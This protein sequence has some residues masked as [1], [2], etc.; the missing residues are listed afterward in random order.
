MDFPLFTNAKREGFAGK[1]ARQE[2]RSVRSKGEI[3]RMV[4]AFQAAEGL[5]LEDVQVVAPGPALGVTYPLNAFVSD[6]VRVE[7]DKHRMILR[8]SKDR[9]QTEMDIFRD[10]L[11]SFLV[12]EIQLAFPE[13]CCEGEWV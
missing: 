7:A 2:G 13:Y 8:F 11:L 12:S 6:H 3:A 10:D 5:V 4:H 9:Q 1:Y